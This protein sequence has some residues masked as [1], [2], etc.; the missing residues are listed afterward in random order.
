MITSVLVATAKVGELLIGAQEG[1]R[2]QASCE[3]C[4]VGDQCRS[5]LHNIIGAL[6]SA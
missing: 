3:K 4:A 6:L 5:Q 2:W 1:Q